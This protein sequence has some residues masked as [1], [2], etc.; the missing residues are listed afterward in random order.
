MGFILIPKI[1]DGRNIREGDLII[2]LESAGLH[3][4]GF[5]LVRSALSKKDIRKY[6]KELL[7][8]T[9]IYVK[10]I[11]SLLEA[12]CYTLS[13]IK[14]V[15]HNTGG[16]F[17]TKITKVLPRG[18]AFKINKDSWKVP[19]IFKIIQKKAHLQDP[20]MYSTFNMGI[21][22]VVVTNKKYA[23]PTVEFLGKNGFKSYI[24]GKVIKSKR[25][26]IVLV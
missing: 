25:R 16:A 12:R 5:S 23:A 11:L 8:P 21:G 7:R 2:G 4:N 3:S 1:I 14:A 6:K 10:P 17:Y 19:R 24:I 20:Q 18:V 26:K 13:A 15:A 9:R 22:M